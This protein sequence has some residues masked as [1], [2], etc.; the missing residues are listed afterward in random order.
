[1]RPLREF[2]QA[3]G[4]AVAAIRENKTRGT[5]TTL[6]IIIGIVGVVTTM[7]AANGISNAFKESV[8]ALGTDVLYVSRTPWIITGNFFEFRNRPRLTLKDVSKL[9]RRLRGARAVT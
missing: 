4:I 9:P 6:G 3:F 2:V 7:T 8:S 5:L 1:M